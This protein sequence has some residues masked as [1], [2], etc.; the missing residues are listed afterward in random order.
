M[1]TTVLV[2]VPIKSEHR[3]TNLD[4][5]PLLYVCLFRIRYINAGQEVFL[6]VLAV[7][8]RVLWWHLKSTCR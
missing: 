2:N 6:L 1:L 7:L 8:V 3:D 5:R 4:F